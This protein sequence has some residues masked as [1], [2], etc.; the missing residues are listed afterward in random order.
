MQ[1]DFAQSFALWR[2]P[3]ENKINYLAGTPM[4]FESVPAAL[5]MRSCQFVFAPFAVSQKFPVVALVGDFQNIVLDE[6]IQKVSIANC[7]FS[8]ENYFS[9]F[10]KFVEPLRAGTLSK[11]VLA[12]RER[13]FAA[14]KLNLLAIFQNA[15]ACYPDAFVYLFHSPLTG[16]WL[17]CSPEILLS[18][19]NFWKTV[20]LAGTQKVGE[21]WDAKNCAEQ[22]L[23]ADF[24]REQLALAG[25]PIIAEKTETVFAGTVGHLKTE[26]NLA[27]LNF[28]QAANLVN[29]LHPTP[30][31]AG[32]PRDDAVDFILKNEAFP[33]EYYAGFVGEW[34]ENSANLFVNL[35]CMKIAGTQL[36]LYAGG[37]L[38]A[39][40]VTENEWQ[41]TTAKLETIK[42]LFNC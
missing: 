40:S 11:I 34:S 29:R 15:L 28:E 16:T 4:T 1:L 18:S 35:R 36:L 13:V 14:D 21:T 5:K 3:R 32:T 25:T 19:Q 12:R 30:A 31:V 6:A 9:Q 39:S 41:E 7:E 8:R 17:G 23:V 26:F 38:L 37:G 24:V 27:P 20:A 33:R 22:K 42:R 2:L 10:E